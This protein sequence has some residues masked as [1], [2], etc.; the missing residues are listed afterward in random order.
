MS[1]DTSLNR[2]LSQGTNAQRLVFTPAPP[3][4]ASGPAQGYFW[5]ET[6]TGNLFSW[7]TGTASWV[8]VST[9]GID[10]DSGGGGG[11][12][13]PTAFRYF[14]LDTPYP[15]NAGDGYT[16]VANLEFHATL[17]GDTFLGSGTASATSS[18]GLTPPPGALTNVGWISSGSS[19]N[20]Q[21][22][23]DLGE[24][25]TSPIVEIKLTCQPGQANRAPY[26]FEIWGSVDGQTYYKSNPVYAAPWADGVHQTLPISFS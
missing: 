5:F 6:D 13:I 25:V 14:V 3:S 8:A 22:F 1:T 11:P 21:W 26:R 16:A 7:N 15:Q 24:G 20:N 12:A 9:V 2:F 23:Y 4:P 18:Y 10:D 19:M 17:G